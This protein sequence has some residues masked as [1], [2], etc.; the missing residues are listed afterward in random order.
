MEE[1]TSATEVVGNERQKDL[2]RASR[3]ERNWKKER[4]KRSRS[5]NH[6]I[7]I[8]RKARMKLLK[9]PVAHTLEPIDYIM[10]LAASVTVTEHKTN[11]NQF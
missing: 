7:D 3:S 5:V 4:K 9:E 6:N 10:L 11:F 1:A 2:E 8:N